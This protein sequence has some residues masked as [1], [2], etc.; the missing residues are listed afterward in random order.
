MALLTPAPEKTATVFQP[1]VDLTSEIHLGYEALL[2]PPGGDPA[3]YL[4]EA[5]AQGCLLEV[6]AALA[7]RA[8]L[9]ARRWRGQKLFFNLTPAS[10]VVPER[11]RD[12][13]AGLAGRLVV[14]LTE[15]AP[16]E[17]LEAFR[18][19]AGAWREL[20]AEIAVDDI[21]RGHSRLLAVSELGPRYL[22]VDRALF[23][24][25]QRDVLVR[26]VLQVA[27]DIGAAVIVEGLESFREVAAARL[28]GVRF[29]QGFYWGRPRS[30]DKMTFMEYANFRI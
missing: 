11:F 25:R 27:A 7:W 4:A 17:D 13:F 12:I 20:G 30:L 16:L 10:F 5:E 14:E 3:A 15:Q 29:G 19:A 21:G 23:R 28:L 9:E 1:V 18:Q 24:S 22:K 2:R 8:A 6:E 26:A